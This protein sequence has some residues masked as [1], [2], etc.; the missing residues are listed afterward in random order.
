MLGELRSN[1]YDVTF[2][3]SLYISAIKVYLI[4]NGSVVLL[5]NVSHDDGVGWFIIL[6]RSNNSRF[7]SMLD[8]W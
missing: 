4:I 8:L 3:P 7:P 1:F 5:G 6:A 2:I